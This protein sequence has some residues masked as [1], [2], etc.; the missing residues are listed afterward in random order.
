VHQF[1]NNFLDA[2]GFVTEVRN[3]VE[4]ITV[5]KT[6]EMKPAL[7]VFVYRPRFRQV[8]Y[9][10]GLLTKIFEPDGFTLNRGIRAPADAK[11]NANN[12]PAGSVAAMIDQDSDILVFKEQKMM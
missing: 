10:V 12:A 3:G 2:L 6:S 9:L 11:A 7:E 4:F 1:L 5:K 8:S